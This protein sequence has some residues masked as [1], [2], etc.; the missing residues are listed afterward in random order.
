MGGDVVQVRKGFPPTSPLFPRRREREGCK[1]YNRSIL[2]NSM[3]M[4]PHVNIRQSLSLSLMATN[5]Q[6]QDSQVMGR[7]RR[8]QRPPFQTPRDFM[9]LLLSTRNACCLVYVSGFTTINMNGEKCLLEAWSREGEGDLPARYTYTPDPSLILYNS[10][11]QGRYSCSFLSR[12][13]LRAIHQLS[14]K[15]ERSTEKPCG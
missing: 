14:S 10:L 12:S 1:S 8:T 5:K 2:I 13:W 6:R 11:V 4:N 7:L 15:R 9:F 3:L